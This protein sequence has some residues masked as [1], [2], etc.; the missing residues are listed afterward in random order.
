MATSIVQATAAPGNRMREEQCV[1]RM[2]L[3][4]YRGMI[5]L[6]VICLI[7]GFVFAVPILW[8][9][10]IVLTVI[11]LILWVLGAAGHTVGPRAH[12]W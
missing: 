1:R 8:T 10:G 5:V 12:Y 7:L 4:T 6:G 9:I 3:G 2:D 11:G